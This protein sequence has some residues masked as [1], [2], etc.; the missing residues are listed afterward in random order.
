MHITRIDATQKLPRI[1]EEIPYAEIL[2]QF[3]DILS[4][5]SDTD[6]SY[7]L[8]IEQISQNDNLEEDLIADFKENREE[9]FHPKLTLFL[10]QLIMLSL[11][12]DNKKNYNNLLLSLAQEGLVS[13]ENFTPIITHYQQENQNK[14]ADAVIQLQERLS[15]F[16]Q[17]N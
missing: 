5:N 2:K 16:F 4:L 11:S 10:E 13:K 12:D 1:D 15:P 17:Q 3:Q 14:K 9:N 8:F 6:F 7:H